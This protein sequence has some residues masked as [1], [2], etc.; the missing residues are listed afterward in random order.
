LQEIVELVHDV[1]NLKM[2]SGTL[3]MDVEIDADGL[4]Q[5]VTV[6]STPDEELAQYVTEVLMSAMYKPGLCSG[7]PCKMSLPFSF[8]LTIVH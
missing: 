8:D 5:N 2:V 1:E 3:S 6:H 4:P 7:T